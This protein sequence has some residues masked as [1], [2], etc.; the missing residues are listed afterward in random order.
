MSRRHS[1]KSEREKSEKD[2]N[3]QQ[4]NP[5]FDKGIGGED[6]HRQ[7]PSE[8]RSRSKSRD[9]ETLIGG[10][11]EEKE[12]SHKSSRSRHRHRARSKSKDS[13]Q[14][15]RSSREKD[16]GGGGGGHRSSSTKTTNGGSSRRRRSRRA[17][18]GDDNR[19]DDRHSPLE[20]GDERDHK[21]KIKDRERRG[22]VIRIKNVIKIKM[23]LIMLKVITQL[24][25]LLDPGNVNLK[26][27]GVIDQRGNELTD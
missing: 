10:G 24:L 8:R 20:P 7:S 12:S 23:R 6:H 13:E 18:D 15:H 9:K 2:F 27:N 26:K 21:D 22:I 3:Q 5:R 19:D 16:E 17:A 11:G 25:Q 1:H 14:Q 4:P